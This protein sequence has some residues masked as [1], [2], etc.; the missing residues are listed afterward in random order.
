M[1]FRSEGVRHGGLYRGTMLRLVE[2][3]LGEQAAL[4]LR[5]GYDF[6]GVRG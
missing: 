3:V 1:L 4:M 6:A 2:A 5:A